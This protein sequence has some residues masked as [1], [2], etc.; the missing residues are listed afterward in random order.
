[1]Q[2][3]VKCGIQVFLVVFI[4]LGIASCNVANLSGNEPLPTVSSLPT[5]QLPDWVEQISPVG[6]TEV[7][8]QIRIRFKEALIPVESIDSPNQQQILEKIA[9]FPPLKGQ[10]RFLTPRMVG[11][12]SESVLPKATR[13]QV[14]LKAG[15]ADLKNHRLEQDLVWTFNTEAIKLTNLPGMT[16][17]GEVEP[18][19]IKPDLKFTSN[20]EL[21]IHIL[22]ERLKLIN[23]GKK[24]VFLLML[25]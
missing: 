21:D 15:L 20:V 25:L 2:A 22:K 12:Q 24:Q 7:R 4:L 10:F 11:F 19:D 14:T 6:E 13:V 1:M 23:E 3:V 9:I 16:E 18:I 8:S 5:P 17:S